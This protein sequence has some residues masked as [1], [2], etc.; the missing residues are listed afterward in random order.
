MIAIAIIASVVALVLI[1]FPGYI[2]ILFPGYI[3]ARLGDS[4]PLGSSITIGTHQ[5]RQL[6]DIGR[7]YGAVDLARL[8]R[9]VAPNSAEDSA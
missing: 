4:P 7:N 1:L 3:G 2:G 5:L 9:I 8:R 6:S